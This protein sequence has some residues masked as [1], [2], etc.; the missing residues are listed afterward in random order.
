MANPIDVYRY[1]LQHDDDA[2]FVA[3]QHKSRDGTWRTISVWMIPA[4]ADR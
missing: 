2:D 4:S 1:E 3:Y